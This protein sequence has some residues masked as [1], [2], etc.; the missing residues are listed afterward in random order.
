MPRSHPADHYSEALAA[1]AQF[2]LKHKAVVVGAWLGLATV[3]ALAFPQ[4]ESVVRQQSV[5]PVPRDVPSFQA[6]DRMGRAFG[7][8]GSTTTVVVAMSNPGG[9]TP[10]VR[11]CYSAM[12]D[13]LRADSGHV[14]LVRDLL[15]DPA[16]A[17]QA[18]SDDGKAWYLPVG[19][20]GT[21][22]SPRAAESV[23]S[24]RDIAAEAFRGTGTEAEVTGPPATMSD[25]IVTAERD[26]LIISLATVG[27][28]AAILLLVYRSVFTALL[29]LLVI[30]LSLAVGRGILAGLGEIGMP[31]SEFTIAFTTVILLGAGTDYSVFLIS[32]YHEQRRQ[33]VPVDQ[34]V[35]HATATIGRVI[36]A[37]AATVALAM[38]AMAF[39][40]LNIFATSGPA[41]AI[42]VLIGFIASV[43]LLPPVLVLAAKRGIGEPRADRT[44]A[45]WN[46]IAATVVRRPVPL[47]AISLVILVAL[48]SMC[49]AMRISYDDRTAQ[50]ADTASNK[51]YRLLDRHFPT[52]A[53]MTEFL[54]V[55]SSK[56]MRTGSGLADLEEMASR[57]SQISGVTQVVGVTRPTGKRLEQAE[58]AWQNGQIGDKLTHVAVDAEGHKSQLRQLTDGADRLADGLTQL[59]TR[60]QSALGPMTSLLDQAPQVGDQMKSYRALLGQLNAMA[61]N[62]DRL[63]ADRESLRPL[64][65]RAAQT[66]GAIEPLAATLDS[67][68]W[69]T[70]TPQCMTLREHVQ[71]LVSLRSGGF[72]DQIAD[73]GD[74]LGTRKDDISVESTIKQIQ[75]AADTLGRSAKGAGGANASLPAQI[76]L[77]QSGIGRLA[78]GARTLA[79]GVHTLADSNIQL[80]TGMAQVAA[81][82]QESA[83]GAEG[84]TSA[85][86]FYL[87][88]DSLRDRQFSQ[89][90]RQFVSRDGET[91]RF[92]IKSKFDPYSAESMAL[93]HKIAGVA[94]AATPNTS[95]A[96]A[97]ISMVG[98]PAVNADIQHLL[99]EDFVRLAGAT[100]IIVGLI[101]VVLLRAVLAPLYLLVTVVL[102]Y[103]AAMGMGV[104]VIRYGLHHD[105]TWP[106]PL[107]SFIILVA[108]GADYN[109]LLI[110]RLREES[111]H[112]I[113]VGVLRTVASTGSVITSAGLIFSASMFGL[114]V[115]SIA[116]MVQ[117]GFII[118]CGL[119]LDTF[120]VRTLMVPAIATL[121]REASWWPGYG[122]QT[123]PRRATGRQKTIR[124]G[125]RGVRAATRN[126]G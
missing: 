61:P 95:L 7:E 63:V 121:L 68:P 37:S 27:L 76:R 124:L 60:I 21:L 115:G 51:G 71:T 8:V 81:Q 38:V 41:C 113:R 52:D 72:F 99:V 33:G 30:G 18:I 117:M 84:V 64:A 55:E 36:L 28:I 19:I 106:V 123:S 69:C 15:A 77:L 91:V 108:V 57:V 83:H 96:G 42:A 120:V 97:K 44:R 118:G 22:G 67:A 112:N 82:L 80:V 100:L 104:L 12:V 26:L 17:R 90:A 119:L 86:G 110:S 11:Q 114:M 107:L 56:D 9:L 75:R 14:E 10:Q 2:A 49:L 31:V 73:L 88:P 105:I 29:P 87:P 58:L 3:L 92:Q 74:Q 62:I 101:L 46:R 85:A 125:L 50:P 94:A 45:Y 103:T 116:T 111:V 5:D 109:M 4:L 39:A 25:Q 16:T 34:A 126:F 48:A 24:V 40:T 89:V 13:R 66:I 65:L 93:V 1:V 54:L 20:A 35:V 78:S 122:R 98:F 43:T 6:L 102:N 79:I 53:T 70:E 59:D 47:L 23:Q 32:R